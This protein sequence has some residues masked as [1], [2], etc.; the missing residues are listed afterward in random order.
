MGSDDFR[1]DSQDFNKSGDTENNGIISQTKKSAQDKLQKK[2]IKLFNELS[3]TKEQIEY[4]IIQNFRT[5]TNLVRIIE[6]LVFSGETRGLINWELN[7]FELFE[8]VVNYNRK[9]SKA[10]FPRT[11]RKIS[12]IVISETIENYLKL[13]GAKEAKG[14][15]VRNIYYCKKGHIQTGHDR[16]RICFAGRDKMHKISKYLTLNQLTT[17]SIRD[18]YFGITWKFKFAIDI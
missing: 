11:N 4:D 13:E 10:E 2:S 12:K 6:K 14:S 1:K 17:G 16:C 5:S 8:S 18:V 9:A 7:E 3:A 15:L